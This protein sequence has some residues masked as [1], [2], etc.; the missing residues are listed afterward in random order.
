MSYQQRNDRREGPRIIGRTARQEWVPKESTTTVVN[1]SSSF[2]S[3]SNGNGGDSNYSSA[4][5]SS[6]HRGGFIQRSYTSSPSNPKK[7]PEI[8]EPNVLEVPQLVQEIQDKLAKGVVECMICYD[9]VERSSPICPHKSNNYSIFHLDCIQKWARAPTSVYLSVVLNLGGNWRCPGCQFV[10]LLTAEEIQYNFFCKKVCS[11]SRCPCG[12]NMITPRC[13]DRKFTCGQPYNKLL[14]CG[15]HGCEQICHQGP[16]GDFCEALIYPLCFCK[17]KVEVLLCREMAIKGDLR[18]IGGV[19]C[20][21]SICGK[22]LSC[23]NH[24]CCKNCHPSPNG[25]CELTPWKN[26]TCCCGKMKMQ[27]ER[28][29]CLDP[30]LTC[31]QTCGKLLSCGI[32]SCKDLC[33]AGDCPPCLVQINEK[34]RCGSSSRT[35]ECYRTVDDKDKFV[36]NKPCE[37]KKN[38]GRHRCRERCCF[39]SSSNNQVVD[40]W[41]PHL[42]LI[43]CG[44]KL[45]CGQH[46]CKSLCHTGHC[47]PCLKLSSLT[48][49][50][51]PC[52]TLSPSCQHPCSVPQLCGHPSS[53]SFHFGDCPPCSIPMV[54]KCIGGHVVL[55]N[56]PYGLMDI[57]C[58]KL[59]GKTRQCGMHACG[60]N[61]HPPPCDSSSGSGSGVKVSCGQVCG[62]HRKDCM[63]T[64]TAKIINI[65][66]KYG[67]KLSILLKIATHGM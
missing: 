36:C 31:S 44:K 54:K 5:P 63:H 53:H 58:N 50:V 7:E 22:K 48:W 4:S 14:E 52:G 34:C 47:R 43:I 57:R 40:D 45:R 56:I 64:S 46:Y 17:K 55:R 15:R 12:K 19:F 32:H 42:C 26:Q 18:Q 49:P 35:V 2:N 13:S 59:C 67:K 25:D 23:G 1:P 33:H 24:F 3:N 65:L 8:L 29:N 38:C 6:R 39:L 60:R 30:I 66:L 16:C 51:L 41:D 9:V 10:Q 21:N 28:Q 61:C 37:R 62:S 20:C 27:S 11:S